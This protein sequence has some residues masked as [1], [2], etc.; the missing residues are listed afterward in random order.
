MYLKTIPETKAENET[1]KLFKY[2]EI[3][4]EHETK[5]ETGKGW[6][7]NETAP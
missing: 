6:K 5:N 4:T 7:E 3:Q 1:E 2:N